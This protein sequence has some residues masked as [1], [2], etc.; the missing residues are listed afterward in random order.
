MNG[1]IAGA[2]AQLATARGPEAFRTVLCTPARI[3]GVIQ[4]PSD[5]VAEG[6]G[7]RRAPLANGRGGARHLPRPHLSK[8]ARRL[9]RAPGC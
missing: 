4:R 1:W 2:V 9:L 6:P 7:T 8:T 5:C 3:V